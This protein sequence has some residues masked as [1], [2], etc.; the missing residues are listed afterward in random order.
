MFILCVGNKITIIVH[1]FAHCL[2]GLLEQPV[3]LEEGQ[4]R[5]KKKVQ[6]WEITPPIEKKE[7]RLSFEQGTGTKLGDIPRIQYQL[8]KKHV[9]DLKPLHRLLFDK[10]GTVNICLSANSNSSNHYNQ[11]FCHHKVNYSA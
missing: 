2:A 4:K 6:R 10:V 3:V 9:E 11:F 7:K 8:Q 5:E 1:V